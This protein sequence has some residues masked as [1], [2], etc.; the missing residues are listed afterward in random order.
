MN[1]P[2]PAPAP[3]YFCLLAP[4]FTGLTYVEEFCTQFQAVSTLSNWVALTPNSVRNSFLPASPV[5]LTSY[6]SPTTAQKS[7]YDELKRLFRQQ[8]KPNAIALKAHVKSVQQ[9]PGQDMSAFYRHLARK[10]YTDDAARN[11]FPFTTFIEGLANS[12]VP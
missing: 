9:L 5:M 6:Q 4:S 11:D 12:V 2:A 8:C 1:A 3:K 10:A 7:S